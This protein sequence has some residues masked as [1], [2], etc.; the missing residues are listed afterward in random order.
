MKEFEFVK[1]L[2]EISPPS[3]CGIGDDAAVIGDLLIAKDIMTEGVHFTRSENIR[4]VIDRLFISNIS[5]IAA[6]GGLSTGFQALLG[7]AMPE[8]FDKKRL[9]EA[10]SFTVKKYNISLIGG[11]TSLSKRE[12]FL[13][14]TIIGKRNKQI[15]TRS[16]AKPGDKVYLSRP[17]GGAQYKLYRRLGILNNY[18][19]AIEMDNSPEHE[20]GE[21]L[22]RT[23]GVNACVDISDG[24]GRDLSQIAAASGVRI[25]IKKAALPLPK[26]PLTHE[27][28]YEYALSSGE[29]YA[30][31]FTA[32]QGTKIAY[33]KPLYEIGNIS[34]GS[35]CFMAE[36]N[37]HLT[38]ISQMGHEHE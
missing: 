19:H 13:T 22:G 38:D 3:P 26:L 31:L 25:I 20:L 24:L 11:D 35:G 34:E 9:I 6:M 27:Q 1:L 28:L 18:Y 5:D 17:T 36:D 21:F 37:G 14:L 16:G 10:I 4:D 32:E 2:K 15:L 8:T 33:D 30:L 23:E 12:L 7:V 29:E